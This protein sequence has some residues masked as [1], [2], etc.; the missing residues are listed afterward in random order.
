MFKEKLVTLSARLFA[1]KKCK[2]HSPFGSPRGEVACNLQHCDAAGSVIIGAVVNLIAIDRL[3]NSQMVE[4][5]CKKNN[6]V[7]QLLI[8]APKHADYIA[9]VP[10]PGPV[11]KLELT[12]NILDVPTMVACGLNAEF[13]KL[14]CQVD[15][16]DQLVCGAASTASPGIL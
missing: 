11:E 13:T 15:G 10:L 9:G 5:C 3:S 2:Y 1:S 14:G 16:C 8:M 4:V 12:R 7:F 6:F